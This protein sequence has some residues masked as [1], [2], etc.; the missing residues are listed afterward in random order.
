[1]SALPK[2]LVYRNQVYDLTCEETKAGFVLMYEY[3]PFN[4][5]YF[6]LGAFGLTKE[7]AINKMMALLNELG[8]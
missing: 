3:R 6:F 1:M 8:N 7:A 4:D 5:D 2:E